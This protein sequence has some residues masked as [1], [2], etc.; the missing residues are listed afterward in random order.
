MAGGWNEKE[1]VARAP[2]LSALHERSLHSGEGN[3]QIISDMASERA[4]R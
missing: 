2:V 4:L 1:L 3:N